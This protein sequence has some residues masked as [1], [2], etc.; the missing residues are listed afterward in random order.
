MFS[1]VFPSG[2]KPDI[3]SWV[4]PV[5]GQSICQLINTIQ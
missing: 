3:F 2:K 1:P 5:E 4:Q